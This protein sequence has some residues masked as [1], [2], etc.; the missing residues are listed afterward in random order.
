MVTRLLVTLP[1]PEGLTVETEDG[2]P[3]ARVVVEGH[4]ENEGRI[5]EQLRVRYRLAPP[6]PDAPAALLIERPLRPGQAFLFRLTVRDEAS[7][8]A[9]SLARGFMVPT[10]PVVRLAAASEGAARGDLTALQ[11]V[12]GPD[13]L[14]LMPPPPE[15]VLGVYRADAVVS[16]TRIKKV[17][18]SVDG[19]A[20]LARTR[21]PYSAEVRLDRLP[22]EQVIRAEGFDDKGELVA[23]DQLVVNQPQGAL[24][25]WI[26]DPPRGAKLSGRLRAKAEVMVPE[27]GKLEAV[28]FRVNDQVVGRLTSPP[29]ELD[30]EVPPAGDTAYLAVVAILESGAVAEDLRFLKA[31][32][33]LEEIEVDLVELLVTALDGSGH[34]VRGLA[35][36]DFEVA[37]SDQPQTITRFEPVDNLPLILGLV[38][39]TSLSMAESLAES[40]RA[41]AGFIKNV[42]TPRDKSFALSFASRP[43]LLMPPVDDAEAVA[44]ALEDL[45]AFGSTALHDAILSA[46]Y[47]FRGQKGQRALVLLTDGDD[48]ASHTKWEDVLEYARRCGVAVFPIG[49]KVSDLKLAVRSKLAN[50]AEA[51]GG[52]VYYIDRADELDGVYDRIEDELRNRYYL[53]YYSTLPADKTGLR[54][55]EVRAKRGLKVRTSRGFAR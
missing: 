23:S 13:S 29:W 7:G 34:P 38:L 19:E 53:A 40:E 48:T 33:N 39:D 15:V 50:L 25:V 44:L 54:R 36:A 45:G 42:L 30:V 47:Y 43:A 55:I 16:G 14:V 3:R 46:L 27:D 2:K 11:G 41:A 22:R 20:Q 9:A 8:A 51:T 18:F 1:S 12:V 31:P 37:E 6:A 17:V 32:A 24:S 21:P 5:F 28:E 49:L 52:A 10:S 4:L 26:T 35:A